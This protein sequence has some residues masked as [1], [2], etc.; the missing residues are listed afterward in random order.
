MATGGL[1]H[2]KVIM[3]GLGMSCRRLPVTGWKLEV[4]GVIEDI[5]FGAWLDN[6]GSE[7]GYNA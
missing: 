1:R 4:F 2:H 3:V 7:L 6:E 5:I